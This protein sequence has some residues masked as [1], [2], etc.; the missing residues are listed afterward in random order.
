MN[1]VQPEIAAANYFWDKLV[2]GGVMILDDYGFYLHIE[3][4]KAF[5]LFAIEK[6][7]DILSLP[8]GQGIIIKK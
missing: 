6:R 7:Q 5:D 8:T 1:C 3:Q 2:V 4:K